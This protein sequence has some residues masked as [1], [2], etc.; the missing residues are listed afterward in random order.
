MAINSDMSPL[1]LVNAGLSGE[2]VK[3]ATKENGTHLRTYKNYR[4]SQQNQDTKAIFRNSLQKLWRM[5]YMGKE[6]AT[7]KNKSAPLRID[8]ASDKKTPP[9]TGPV[10]LSR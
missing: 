2:R 8:I 4:L 1:F 7:E 5:S 3:G 10:V 9:S 6:V